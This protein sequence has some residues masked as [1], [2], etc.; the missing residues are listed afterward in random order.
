M[1]CQSQTRGARGTKGPR[2]LPRSR[3]IAQHQHRLAT[4]ASGRHNMFFSSCRGAAPQ[5]HARG[6]LDGPRASTRRRRAGGGWWLLSSPTHAAAHHGPIP[7]SNANHTRSKRQKRPG[8][9]GPPARVRRIAVQGSRG[10]GGAGRGRGRGCGAPRASARGGWAAGSGRKARRGLCGRRR[11]RIG[12]ARAMLKPHYLS[13]S[14][15][16]GGRPGKCCTVQVAAAAPTR[17]VGPGGAPGS[18][19]AHGGPQVGSVQG[20]RPHVGAGREAQG[21]RSGSGDVGFGPARARIHS[22]ERGGRPNTGPQQW[23]LTVPGCGQ[24]A[25]KRAWQTTGPALGEPPALR[26]RQGALRRP[27]RAGAP[28]L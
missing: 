6:P 21:V 9:A 5:V 23:A 12:C 7:G 1:W 13:L 19:A 27:P 22:A 26:R 11:A 8:P 14:W 3:P 28:A 17:P 10:G 15:G 24:S 25:S 4:G 20:A 16:H 2:R 18:T